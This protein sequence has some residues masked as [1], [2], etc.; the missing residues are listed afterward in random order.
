MIL[1]SYPTALAPLWESGEGVVFSGLAGGS[2]E[3]GKPSPSWAEGGSV[4]DKTAFIPVPTCTLPW[5]ARQVPSRRGPRTVSLGTRASRPRQ[6]CPQPGLR[7]APAQGPAG[8]GSLQCFPRPFGL[9]APTSP[10]QQLPWDSLEAT[11]PEELPAGAPGPRA[12]L[13]GPDPALLHE[14]RS[15]ACTVETACVPPAQQTFL[16]LPYCLSPR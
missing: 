7:E 6:P 11:V 1:S 3:G 14:G 12:H 13:Q 9:T 5:V 4:I 15:R 16:E 8:A 2:P 10:G